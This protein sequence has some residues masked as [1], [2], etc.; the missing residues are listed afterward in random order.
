MADSTKYPAK[1]WP[2]YAPF[3]HNFYNFTILSFF[4]RSNRG[5]ST[6]ND[7]YNAHH[8]ISIDNIETIQEIFKALRGI[9]DTAKF[10]EVPAKQET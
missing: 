7:K 10:H 5:T 8:D 6:F 2:S 1:P 4:A 9:A 3:T